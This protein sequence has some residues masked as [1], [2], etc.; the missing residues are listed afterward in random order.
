VRLIRWLRS[1]LHGEVSAGELEARRAAGTVAYSLAEEAERGGEPLFR[2]CAWNAFALQTIADKLLEADSAADPATEGYVP[3]STALYMGECLDLVQHWIRFARVAQSDPAARAPT[4]LPARLPPWE[5][6]EPTRRSELDGLRAAYEALQARVDTALT[7]E[8]PAELRRISAEMR[9]AADYA[10]AI[11]FANAGPIER[12]EIRT[13]LL[14]AL[15]H[16]FTLGQL[17]AMPTL[18][19]LERVRR[20]RLA[21]L[22]L[23][24]RASW[25]QIGPGWPVLDSAGE[26]VGLVYRVGGDRATGRFEGVDVSRSVGSGGL[27][28]PAEVI[29]QIEAGQIRLSVPRAA[30]S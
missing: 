27:H 6:D 23:G 18:A 4:A 29:E 3:R 8:S 30:L 5:H 14:E 11:W 24:P 17:L 26:A 15:Q 22:P 7:A 9:S 10:V 20:D 2:L 13:Y 16:A 25:L 1:A 19:E 28:V 21:G 12:G